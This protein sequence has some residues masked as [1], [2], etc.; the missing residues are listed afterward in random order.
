MNEVMVDSNVLIDVFSEDPAW[1]SWSS[2][3]LEEYADNFLLV[4]NPVIYAEISVAFDDIEVLEQALPEQF[5]LKAPIPFEASFLAGKAF[6][7][8]RKN[9]GRK[10]A[11]LPDFLIGAH[12]A[13]SGMALITRDKSRYQAYF[14][15]VKIIS[16]QE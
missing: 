8:Y 13:V 5:F 16:P 7:R 1:F 2:Q 10:H 15:S 9:E 3:T 12:A 11:V 6:L 14:P 4:I